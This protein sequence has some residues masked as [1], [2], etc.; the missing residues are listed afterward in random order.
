MDVRVFAPAELEVALATLR[1]IP[2]SS[3][4]ARDA[5]LR[6]I[7]SLHGRT[8]DPSSLPPAGPVD[9][10]ARILDPHGRKRLVELATVVAMVDGE[11]TPAAAVAVARLAA[12]L[13]VEGW[14]SRNLA[15]L[16]HR[17]TRLLR[18]DM[19]RRAFGRFIGQAVRARDLGSATEVAGALLG[20]GG[21]PEKARRYRALEHLPA[22]SFGRAYWEHCASRGFPFP[23]ERG[24]LPERAIF[25]DLGHVLAGYD[26]DPAGEIQQAAFQAGFVRKQ[27][28]LFLFF[29]IA[30][31]HLGV[32]LTPIAAPETGY[33]DV[34]KV[35]HALAR[36]AA[37]NTDLSDRWSFWPLL[38]R[39]LDEVRHALEI[40]P[41]GTCTSAAA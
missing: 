40:P 27:G 17:R 31:F 41:L 10:A 16:A 35:V 32:K 19:G 24:G 9:A 36:G 18:L 23:G 20:R 34:P 22:G 12:A 8:V 6:A 30:Q 29:G 37:C 11:V 28:F 21:N 4:P 26:T 5:L 39:P 2:P 25:H 13:A 1:A 38:P 15:R 7:G 3:S 14:E 33:L